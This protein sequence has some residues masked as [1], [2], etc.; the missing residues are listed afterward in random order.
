MESVHSFFGSSIHFVILLQQ[1]LSFILFFSEKTF[2]LIFMRLCK[3]N[4]ICMYIGIMQLCLYCQHLT[5]HS[6]D[7]LM[8]RHSSYTKKILIQFLKNISLFG[9]YG[10][11]RCSLSRSYATLYF[12]V[13][14]KDFFLKIF[15]HD[16]TQQV[17]TGNFNV[18]IFIK[19]LLLR[20]WEFRV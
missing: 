14:S 18:N 12:L 3:C 2:E 17:E 7:I 9:A 13:Y 1:P 16:G 19:I 11:F 4:Y 8:M 5:N 20:K 10:K 6:K 15:Q